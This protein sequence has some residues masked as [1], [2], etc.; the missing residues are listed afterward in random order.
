MW[1]KEL[2]DAGDIISKISDTQEEIQTHDEKKS[3]KP[4]NLKLNRLNIQNL[5]AATLAKLCQ[6]KFNASAWNDFVHCSF[7]K[8]FMYFSLCYSKQ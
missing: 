8:L 1:P 4:D 7:L 3:V 5:Q 6:V 2:K